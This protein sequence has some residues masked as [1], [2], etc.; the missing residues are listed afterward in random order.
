MPKTAPYGSWKSPITSDLVAAQSTALSEVRL[1]G[2]TIYWLEG[3]PQEQGRLV[4][5]RAGGRAIDMT[6]KPT[7][8]ERACMSTVARLGRSLMASSISQTSWMADFTPKKML[9]R[10]HAP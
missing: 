8:R 10:V 7:V 5:V 4:V 1:D 6:P 2:R 3:R 9:M